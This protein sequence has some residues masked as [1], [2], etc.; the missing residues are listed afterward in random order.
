MEIKK[1][2]HKIKSVIG[3]SFQIA[4]AN[5]KVRNEGSFLGI[6]WYLLEPLAFFVIL[7]FIGGLISQNSIEKYPMYLFLGI[8]MF[9]FFTAVTISSTEIIQ[10]NADF[11]KSLKVNK[12]SFVIS[13]MLQFIFSHFFEFIIL[14]ILTIFMKINI[15]F[16]LSYPIIFFLFCL[17]TMGISFMLSVFGV[18]VNDL[19]NVWSVFVRLLWFMTPVFYTIGGSGLIHKISMFN[20]LYHFINISR[21]IIIYHRLPQI[22]TMLLAIFYSVSIFLIGLFIF[23]KNKN[24]LAEKI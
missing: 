18:Y 17:F 1:F 13:V 19:K 15:L 12:E 5:F 6:F 24:K 10:G 16:L 4:K 22:N 23:E 2:W 14:V 9:N 20:P 7:L 8:M 3:L 21:D 11:I